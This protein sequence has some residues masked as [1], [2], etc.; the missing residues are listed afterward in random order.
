MT[1]HAKTQRIGLFMF[2]LL[3]IL[4]MTLNND[5]WMM[6]FLI[7][8]SIIVL[9]TIFMN[10]KVKLLDGFLTFRVCIFSIS[11]YNRTVSHEQISCMKFKRIGRASKCVIVKNHKG[12]NF[13]ITN[14]SPDTL[15]SDL[16][17][18]ANEYAIPIFKTKDYMMLEK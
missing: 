9:V 12:F 15:Y 7:P 10:F 18:F 17:D 4:L 1:Y 11:I 5:T 2:L 14:F 3:F 6:C 8:V 13:R 16:I